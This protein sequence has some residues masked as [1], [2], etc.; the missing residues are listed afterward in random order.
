MINFKSLFK[1]NILVKYSRRKSVF[2]ILL[3]SLLI[4][5][6]DGFGIGIIVPLLNSNGND[7]HYSFGNSS[8]GLLSRFNLDFNLELREAIVFVVVVFLLKAIMRFSLN[9][10]RIQMRSYFIK[11]IR[12][13]I[14]TSVFNL[15]FSTFHDLSSDSLYSLLNN[16]VQKLF[17]AFDS[18]FKSWSG[19]I[20]VASYF[21][22][23]I[24]LYTKFTLLILICSF[25][26][27]IVYRKIYSL[28]KNSSANIAQLQG[29]LSKTISNFIYNW[30]Y[31]KINGN[32]TDPN[33]EFNDVSKDVE[34]EY[35][36]MGRLQSFAMSSRE[37]LSLSVVLFV[38][39]IEVVYFGLEI[40]STILPLLLLY[41]IMGNSVIIQ[42]SWNSFL[43]SFGSVKLITDFLETHAS[44]KK[45]TEVRNAV[46]QFDKIV[47]EDVCFSYPNSNKI[48]LHNIN[49]TFNRGELHVIKGQSGKGKSTLIRLFVGLIQPINGHIMFDG[50][51][52][53][54][55]DFNSLRM[56]TSYSGG[57]YFLFSGE[58]KYYHSC[59]HSDEKNE[60]GINSIS[61][62]LNIQNL[63]QLSETHPLESQLS[64]GELQRVNLMRSLLTD[65]DVWIFDEPSSQLDTD[66]TKLVLNEINK[67]K[68]DKFVIVITHD[69]EFDEVADRVT[70]L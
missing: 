8:V 41:R 3:L 16:E 10:I 30:E 6:F 13:R 23:A 66:S 21:I 65:S 50:I 56:A 9:F 35:E 28:T 49:L 54:E 59:F 44:H 29:R 52:P 55:D 15:E 17:G 64:A 11:S 12:Q 37:F 57:R 48:I 36:K 53:S 58:L 69:N 19:V 26:V 31:F 22:L 47:F 27:F 40:K 7:L 68:K 70:E 14:Y 18:Y 43:M 45:P 24:L 67:L 38:V 63:F 60:F 34:V 39:F 4:A 51:Q 32:F 20:Q 25:F 33:K 62:N 46:F 5:I 1:P 2:I 61:S 42:N